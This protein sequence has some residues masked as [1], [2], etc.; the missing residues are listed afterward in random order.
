MPDRYSSLLNTAYA[1]FENM[2]VMYPAS[3]PESQ[4]VL[5]ASQKKKINE[6][7]FGPSAMDATLQTSGTIVA[8]V[9]KGHYASKDAFAADAQ[10]NTR[11]LTAQSQGLTILLPSFDRE[12]VTW[13]KQ[14]ATLS[15]DARK[16]AVTAQQN[17]NDQLGAAVHA[18]VLDV[19]TDFTTILNQWPEPRPDPGPD[20]YPDPHPDPDPH[21]HPDPDPHPHPDPDPTPDPVDVSLQREAL[22]DGALDG[23]PFIAID[24]A[25]ISNA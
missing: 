24:H 19:N 21:P 16:K 13:I 17:V 8:N 20:P 6:S 10:K 23:A 7:L 25:L 5:Q 12:Y 15:W 22:I 2:C 3:G 4:P 11:L 18:I 1:N 9:E 14:G